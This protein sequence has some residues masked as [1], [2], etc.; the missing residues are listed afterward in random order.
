M[1]FYLWIKAHFK[2]YVSLIFLFE[3]FFTQL[4]KPLCGSRALIC[5]ISVVRVNTFYATTNLSSE[6]HR[7][8]E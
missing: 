2:Y 5:Q 6:A 4:M 8:Q 3:C 7:A 1:Q